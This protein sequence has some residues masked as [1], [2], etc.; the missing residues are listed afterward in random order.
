MAESAG[1]SVADGIVVDDRLRTSH[2]DV[3]AAGDG[4][5]FPYAALGR[6]VRVEHWDN[7][8]AQGQCAGRNMAGADEPYLHMP[9]FFS[10]LFEFGYEAVGEV[11]T[12]LEMVADWQVEHRKGVIYYL[13]GGRV[14]GAMMCDLWGKVDVARQLVRDGLTLAEARGALVA[15]EPA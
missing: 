3:F 8:S 5:S 9:Y 4:A 2:E 11:D 1:L 13:A 7:A 10:D 15:P 14:R 12:R 6:S